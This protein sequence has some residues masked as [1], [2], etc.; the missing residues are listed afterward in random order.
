MSDGSV[1]CVVL[2][3][4]VGRVHCQYLLWFYLTWVSGSSSTRTFN[5]ILR[6]YSTGD[7]VTDNIDSHNTFVNGCLRITTDYTSQ[8]FLTALN[9]LLFLQ[10]AKSVSQHPI[11]FLYLTILTIFQP[12][13]VIFPHTTSYIPSV[14]VVSEVTSN[15][16]HSYCI[17]YC[18]SL[19][20]IY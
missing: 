14:T 13:F 20:I 4:S 1:V 12:Y 19:Y 5:I 3:A 18:H 9:T 7:G 11:L 6:Y 16:L 2:V 10:L 8:Q 15:M 17:L